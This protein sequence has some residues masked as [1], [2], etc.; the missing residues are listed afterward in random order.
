MFIQKEDYNYLIYNLLLVL[1][2]LECTEESKAFKDFRRIG[3]VM[4]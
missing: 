2:Y 3:K 4:H 1:N